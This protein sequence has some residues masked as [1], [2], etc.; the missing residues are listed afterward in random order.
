MAAG[1]LGHGIWDIVH[2]IKDRLVSRSGAGW[3]AVI[4]ILI[5]ASLIIV[6]LIRP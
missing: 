2:L 6:P 1:W 3:C 4:D 5:T